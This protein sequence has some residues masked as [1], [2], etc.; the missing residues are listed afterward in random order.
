MARPRARIERAIR[1]YLPLPN[2]STRPSFY[3]RERFTYVPGRDVH[4]CPQGQE[5]P[6]RVTK[7]TD[8]AH[9]YQARAEVCNHETAAC[10]SA[11]SKRKVWVEPLFAEAKTLHGLRRFRLRGIEKVNMEGL[12]TAAGQNIKRL[13]RHQGTGS[14]LQS[15]AFLAALSIRILSRLFRPTALNQ[16]PS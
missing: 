2:W 1:A 4:L 9:L 13:I 12:M 8:H 16:A 5:F 7:H 6:K 11:I 15:L 14:P 10:R 3:G